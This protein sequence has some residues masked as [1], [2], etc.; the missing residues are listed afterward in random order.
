[1]EHKL[2]DSGWDSPEEL[3]GLIKEFENDGW[4][5]A[6]VGEIFSEN[7]LVLVRFNEVPANHE[8]IPVNVNSM[9]ELKMVIAE[10]IAEGYE[11]CAIGESSGTPII[12][13]RKDN[14]P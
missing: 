2:V 8:V 9:P 3:A 13:V 6:A 7:I 12:I 4:Y 1:M 11:I 10:K 5:V 14:K